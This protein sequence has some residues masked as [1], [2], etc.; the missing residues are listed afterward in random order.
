[1]SSRNSSWCLVTEM[2]ACKRRQR[3]QF[4][5]CC[6]KTTTS[7]LACAPSTISGTPIKTTIFQYRRIHPPSHLTNFIYWYASNFI[8]AQCHHRDRQPSSYWLVA[9]MVFFL[10]C[11]V[12]AI[13]NDTR[14]TFM[15]C[16][17]KNFDGESSTCKLFWNDSAWNCTH[18]HPTVDYHYC[19]SESDPPYHHITT[20]FGFQ[21][22][23]SIPSDWIEPHPKHFSDSKQ[24]ISCV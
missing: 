23:S 24:I 6:S 8:R 7:L 18:H 2:Q 19:L 21:S 14:C 3:P 16:R 5:S 4:G 12:Q 15:A 11:C 13:R 1:M 10:G 17:V 20:H 22:A 9:I